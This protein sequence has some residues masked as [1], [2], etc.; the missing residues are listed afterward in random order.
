VIPQWV[1]PEP[2]AR[3]RGHVFGRG[4]RDAVANT[5]QAYR[6]FLATVGWTTPDVVAAGGAVAALLAERA[7][8][9]VDEV[10]GI[11]QG[12]GESADELF[13]LNARTELLAG[14]AKPECSA[15]GILPALSDSGATYLA[16]NWD[17][18]PDLKPSRV[19][20][21]IAPAGGERWL[22]TFT[23]AGIVGKIG[24]N[25]DG[26]G[27]CLNILGTTADGGLHGLP[28]HVASRLVLAECRTLPEALRLL[29]GSSFAASS[30]FNLACDGMATA[31][32]VSPG[33]VVPLPPAAGGYRVH[34]NHFVVPPAQGSDHYVRTWPDSL[35]RLWDVEGALERRQGPVGIDELAGLLRSHTGG[36]LGVCGH[37]EQNAEYADRQG[38]LAS[39]IMD[40]THRRLLVSDGTP[41]VNEYREYE[42]PGARAGAVSA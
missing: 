18:H 14:R 1:S 17:W 40:L 9:L 38:T 19:V 39:L 2:T 21:T 23:E 35:V 13:A 3:E 26:L 20:W 5:V 15:I 10:E 36:I 6:S 22:T 12:A 11:A 32:E 24:L 4:M 29:I 8:D 27:L 16:Q 7:P 30:C 25:S 37:D 42:L 28:V 34:T 41:C 31:V 33:G